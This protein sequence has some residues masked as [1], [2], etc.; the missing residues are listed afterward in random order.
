MFD[1]FLF[2]FGCGGS[3][4]G[5]HV[6][7]SAKNV[8]DDLNSDILESFVTFGE[9]VEEK[10]QVFFCQ[11]LESVSNGA[12]MLQYFLDSPCREDN[13]DLDIVDLVL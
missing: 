5:E 2:F 4:H 1:R 13:I 7:V 3:R 6:W 9:A 12:S 11:V 8:A 10:C